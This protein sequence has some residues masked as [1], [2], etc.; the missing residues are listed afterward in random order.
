MAIF[1][2]VLQTARLQARAVICSSNIRQIQASLVAY[3]N[4]NGLFPYGIIEDDL[5]LVLMNNLAGNYA[6]VPSYDKTGKW[7]FQFLGFG[8]D[9]AKPNGRVLWCPSRCVKN[10]YSMPNILCGNYG[11]NRVICKDADTAPNSR[12]ISTS[13]KEYVGTPLSVSKISNPGSTLLIADSGYSLISWQGATD[14][15]V[16][17]YE[18]NKRVP[19]F[20]VPGMKANSQR[21]LYPEHINDA[22]NGRH[23]GKTVNVGYA[24]GH[25]NRIKAEDLFVPKED[26]YP[27]IYKN[28]IPK[29]LISR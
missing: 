6:G 29:Q 27:A 18:I 14:A 4:Q 26:I 21:T 15:K 19:S 24:D 20:Y 5:A 13:V 16:K 22:I 10:N 8:F 23:L 2:P 11:V 1:V 7:W 25:L 28:W 17:P 3:E 9:P 12:N